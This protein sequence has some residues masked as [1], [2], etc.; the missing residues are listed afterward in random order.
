MLTC[1]SAYNCAFELTAKITRICI[2]VVLKIGQLSTY[3]IRTASLAIST[4][5]LAI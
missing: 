1:L 2:M 4:W 3:S 5:S